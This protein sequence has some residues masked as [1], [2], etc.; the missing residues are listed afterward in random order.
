[1]TLEEIMEEWKKDSEI[2]PMELSDHSIQT[3]KLHSKYVGILSRNRLIAKKLWVDYKEKKDWKRKYFKGEF[4]NPE[5]MAE[6][7]IEPY[8]GR[9]VAAEVE[10]IL[11]SDTELNQILLKKEY[12][13][14]I[15][16]FCE[17]VIK[18][19]NNRT[20]AIGNA[21]RYNIFLGGG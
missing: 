20:Y 14:E 11:D 7:G 2:D 16:M 9:H 15:V 13:E 5:D 12:H 21:I 10:S 1:M 18:E 6:Y 8:R 17:S 19:L 4:N 3:G